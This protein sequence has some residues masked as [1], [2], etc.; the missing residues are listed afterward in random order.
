MTKHEPAGKPT[1][2]QF[3]K[4][5]GGKTRIPTESDLPMSMV[6]SGLQPGDIGYDAM[7]AA[8][9]TRATTNVLTFEEY[10]LAVKQAT[11]AAEAYYGDSTILRMADYEY[12]TLVDQI[13]AYETAHPDQALTHGLTTAV[14][15][16]TN[17]GGEV[18]H[19]TPM[20]S[21]D[22]V[23]ND[24]DG[25]ARFIDTVVAAGGSVTIEPKMDGLA[26]RAQ[27]INGR[28]VQ[29]ATRGDGITGED[30]TAQAVNINGEGID[31]LPLQLEDRTFTGFVMGET[32]MSEDNF[33]ASNEARMAAGKPTFAN[34]RN[35]V[36]G[37]LRRVDSE[38]AVHMSFAAYG[39]EMDDPNITEY[40]QA[41]TVLES[42]GFRT[43]QS[44]MPDYDPTNPNKGVRTS[45]KE[46]IERIKLLETKRNTLGFP[47][48][49]AVI[50]TNSYAVRKILGTG[51]R[52][53]KF[54]LAYKYVPLEKSSIIK[55]VEI[56]IGRTGRMGMRVRI[57]PVEVDGSVIEY[58]S[59]HSVPWLDAQNIGIGSR[60]M[61]KKAGDVIPRVTGGLNTEENAHI[62]KWRA[63]NVCP[64]CGKPWD[65]RQLVWRCTGGCGTVRGISYFASRDCADID[66]MSDA[67]S[68]ALVRAGK[69]NDIGDLY[70][71]SVVDIATTP[72]GTN[73]A[74]TVRRIGNTVA[75]KIYNQI[76]QSK[77]Q[78]A[79]KILAGV[80]LRS[81]GRSLSRR[82]M[83]HFGSFEKLRAAT[84]EQL[85]E[86][87][88]VGAGKAEI[89]HSELREK[90]PIIDKLV[91]A[92]VKTEIDRQP[93]RTSASPSAAPLS[94]KTVVVTGAMTGPLAA[95][96][97]NDMNVLI[98]DKGGKSSGSVSA[99]TSLLVCG[100]P[101]S[102][103]YQKAQALGIP[104]MTPEEFAELIGY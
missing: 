86:V 31:G 49:G 79:A 30:V 40:S 92:G 64:S 35:A 37:S 36:A 23:T 70:S 25:A 56:E 22:K 5:T 88:G 85:A 101:G 63:P 83:N 100:E 61:V 43:A 19:S 65:K 84:V 98:E 28:L 46:A 80:G 16:G 51:T 67:I 38:Y 42:K 11:E 17:A 78:N 7:F 52:A 97:R 55:D 50:A 14:A 71:L 77:E 74:G 90:A 10:E 20:L 89:I 103:K 24:P 26:V 33:F 94:G 96:K 29:L 72:M 32:Y 91:S 62:Q 3:A 82:L 93:A 34:P 58:A 9:Q 104:I 39:A 48:D 75:T 1:G 87:E 6:N 44:L 81:T 73:D 60:V 13:T 18:V 12:D 15:A 53:P 47:I 59:A 66:G 54:A 8:F 4:E 21:L 99:N 41:M 69:I 102:S 68:G 2:G 27:Y 57:E 95:L 45:S 76:Q